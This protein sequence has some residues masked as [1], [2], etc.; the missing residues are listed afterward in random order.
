MEVIHI[1]LGKSNPNRMNGV[2]KVVYQ[3]ATKQAEY[4]R[5]V[6][7]WGITKNVV[8]DY[9]ERNFETRLFK[10]SLTPFYL[11][12]TLKE[13]ILLKKGKAVFHMHGGWVPFYAAL[14]HYLIKNDIPFV[15]TAHGSYNT[16]AM[17]RSKW[18]KKIYFL[19]FEKRL[20]RKA[21][22]VHFIGKS[23]VEGL[24]RI[25]KIK[26]YL[27]MPYG[28]NSKKQALNTVNKSST[29][30]TVGFLGR[31]DIHTKGL[32][33]LIHAFNSFQKTESK[34]RLWIIGDGKDKK[35]L[36]RLI[37][38]L[39]LQNVV[40]LLG[41][42]FDKEKVDLIKQMDVFVHPSRNEG[43]PVAVL[44]ACELG[45]PCIVSKATNMGM[46]IKDSKAGITVKNQNINELCDAMKNLSAKHKKGELIKYSKNAKRMV[47]DYFNWKK[48]VGMLD[49]L[50]Q[51]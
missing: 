31:L 13:E 45:I 16:I 51:T 32:D 29:N 15:L 46:Y 50:Y 40:Q 7:I 8:H 47:S 30:F 48:I 36:E 14:S 18:L 26:N 20:L 41:S 3:L 42:K 22:K 39:N 12:A 17:K 10:A 33:L 49:Q 19:L 11:S 2:N 38:H 24:K 44:E 25:F 21:Q 37:N 34:A 5:K 35:K 28:F 27:L 4:G 9:G 43:L 6:S 23:E 1:I